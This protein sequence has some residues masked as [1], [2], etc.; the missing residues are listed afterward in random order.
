MLKSI[1]ARKAGEG[2]EEKR[3]DMNAAGALQGIIPKNI[4]AEQANGWLDWLSGFCTVS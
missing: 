4:N 1:R 3:K 2:E